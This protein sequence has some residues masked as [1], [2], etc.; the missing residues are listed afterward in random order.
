MP[1]KKTV[2][3]TSPRAL[4]LRVLSHFLYVAE[5]GSNARL[6]KYIVIH[7][8][9]DAATASSGALFTQSSQESV[10]TPV[11]LAGVGAPLPASKDPFCVPCAPAAACQEGCVPCAHS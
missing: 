5:N 6:A 7:K 4:Y 8:S 10:R 1:A 2:D 3:G 11:R 9:A